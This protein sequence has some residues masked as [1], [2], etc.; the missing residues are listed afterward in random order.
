MSVTEADGNNIFHLLASRSAVPEMRDQLLEIFKDLVE[1]LTPGECQALLKQRNLAGFRP[2]EHAM[3]ENSYQLAE[4]MLNLS[5]I[6][7][8]T[9]T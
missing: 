3:I 7:G 2:L 4:A 8:Q 9:G 5:D 1:L 6:C